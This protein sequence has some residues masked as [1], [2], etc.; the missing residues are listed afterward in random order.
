M[1]VVT[2]LCADVAQLLDTVGG[3]HEVIPAAAGTDGDGK[4]GQPPA[5]PEAIPSRT[6]FAMAADSWSST[7]SSSGIGGVASLSVESSHSTSSRE[8]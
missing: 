4:V 3:Q 7:S 1:V 6:R 2:D 5:A 8:M